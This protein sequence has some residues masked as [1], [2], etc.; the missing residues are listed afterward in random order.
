MEALPS[1][2][3]TRHE[4]TPKTFLNLVSF[5][6]NDENFD[7]WKRQAL[8]TVKAHKLQKHLKRDKTPKKFLLATDD[9][10]EQESQEYLKLEQQ[11]HHLVAWLL[12][13]TPIKL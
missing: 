6:L 1:P 9:E 13:P 10:T 11:D 12:K 3:A 4:F 8:A 7:P 5:K 2:F